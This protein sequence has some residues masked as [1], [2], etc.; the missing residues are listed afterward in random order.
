M[1]NEA[2]ELYQ[3]IDGARLASMLPYLE[4]ELTK[5]EAAC[6]VRMDA[7]MQQGKL[8][9][10]LAQMGWIEMLGYRRL[11]R[12]FQTQVRVGVSLG[13]KNAQTLSGEPR[14]PIFPQ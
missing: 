5:M 2:L 11:K 8:S 4:A 12:R 7:L 3:A 13:E 6:V 1:T 14:L 10:E 9:P